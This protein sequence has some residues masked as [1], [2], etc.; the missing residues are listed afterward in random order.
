MPTSGRKIGM[1]AA[2]SITAMLSSVCDATWPMTSPVTS[3]WARTSRAIRSRDA[4]HQPPV[5]DH[6]QSPGHA[7]RHL[8]LQLAERHEIQP[9]PQ[10]IARQ[11]LGQ[12]PRLLLRGVRQERRAVEVHE[13]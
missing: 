8:P 12:P 2:L 1:C 3:A 9:R 7:Q 6:A 4:Q 11:H 5:D 10:L 13:A